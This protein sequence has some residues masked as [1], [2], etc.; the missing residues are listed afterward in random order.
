VIVSLLGILNLS[1]RIEILRLGIFG[2]TFDPPH[3]GHMILAM[4]CAWQMQL[5]RVL[6][7]LTPYPPHKQNQ[8]ITPLGIRRE[9]VESALLEEPQFE[10]STV[11]MDRSAPHYAVDTVR[12]L[13]QKFP[14]TCLVYLMGADSLNDL[15][16]WHDPEAF[17]A[18]CDEIGVMRRSGEHIVLQKTENKLPG[19]IN[20]IK[21]V[22]APLIEISSTTIRERTAKNQPFRYFVTDTVYQLIQEKKLYQPNR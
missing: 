12:L 17:I 20:K 21:L 4:E 16:K 7:V 19:I 18:A 13:R 5:D 1:G 6:W 8:V 15:P 14:N 11:D 2:G 3:L 9:L 10:L 22:N